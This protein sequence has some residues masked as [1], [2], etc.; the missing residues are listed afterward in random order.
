MKDLDPAY[1]KEDDKILERLTSLRF[2]AM[3]TILLFKMLKMRSQIRTQEVQ[4]SGNEADPDKEPYKDHPNMV[5]Q[6]KGDSLVMSLFM[7]G[8]LFIQTEGV[9][10]AIY[11]SVSALMDNYTIYF[12]TNTGFCEYIVQV[13]LYSMALVTFLPTC[14]VAYKKQDEWY[15][16]RGGVWKAAFILLMVVTT[17]V[18]FVVRLGLVYRAGW[19]STVDTMFEGFKHAKGMSPAVIVA[20]LTPPAVDV[21]QT[22]TLLFA[23]GHTKTSHEQEYLQ[24]GPE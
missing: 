16:K 5:T 7:T 21:L 15:T 3:G 4:D 14:L 20:V 9:G 19:A 12:V 17:G 6:I 24:Q 18:S 13:S 10:L 23:S 22:L 1:C 2:I 8:C 11:F